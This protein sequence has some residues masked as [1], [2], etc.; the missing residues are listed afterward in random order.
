MSW[1]LIIKDLGIA[2]IIAY[3]LKVL[4]EGFFQ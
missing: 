1:E 3:S 4:I 2:E